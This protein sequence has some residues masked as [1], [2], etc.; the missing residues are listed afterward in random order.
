M[1]KKKEFL[2]LPDD[3][4]VKVLH[5]PPRQEG[6]LEEEKKHFA[7]KKIKEFIK[8]W[9]DDYLINHLNDMNMEQGIDYILNKIGLK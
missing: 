2:N 1:T 3:F 4:V 9:Y 6:M 7:E 8:L 5:N